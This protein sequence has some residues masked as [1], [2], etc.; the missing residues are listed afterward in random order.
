L[1]RL[2]GGTG[3]H[4]D[5]PFH[6]ALKTSLPLLQC[7]EPGLEGDK[8]IFHSLLKGGNPVLQGANP[9]SM[10][11]IRLYCIWNMVTVAP[12]DNIPTVM[13]VVMMAIV[14]ADITVGLTL[15]IPA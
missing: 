3:E 6:H 7:R 11:S 1:V 4:F 2:I 14:S 5:D 10:E 8:P 9:L 12:N 13:M 15:E